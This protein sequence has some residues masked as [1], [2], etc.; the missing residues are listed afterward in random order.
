MIVALG[1]RG[2][3]QP[4]VALG[5]GLARAGH[6]VRVLT[7]SDFQELVES[8]GLEFVNAGGSTEA[9][10]KEMQD[11][12]EQGN[13]LKILKK[14]GEAANELSLEA[15]KRGLAA[16][17]GCELIIAGLGGLSIASSLA[18]KLGVRFIPAYLYPYSPTREFPSVL[19]GIPQ[20]PLTSWLNPLS[21]RLGQQMMWQA[22]RSSTNRARR[23]VFGLQ[24]AAFWG[25]SEGSRQPGDLVLYGYSPHVI[26]VPRD[27][28]DRHV[29]TGYWFLDESD[30]WAPPSE[31][32]DFLNAGPAPVYVGF[33]SMGSKNAESTA[34]LVLEA[35]RRTGQRGVL[36]AGW[37]GL[38]KS[39]VPDGVLMVGSVPHSWLFSRMAAVVHHGGAGT[40][41]AGFRAGVPAI[42]TPVLGDQPFWARRAHAL[43]VAPPPVMRRHLTVE[44]LAE[45]ITQATT[46]AAMRRKA[47]DLGKKIRGDDGVARAI[48]ALFQ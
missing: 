15:A 25:A 46:D 12:L 33:G 21:H 14:M 18:E 35:L 45:A 13:F 24:R 1:S 32:A 34:D 37:G 30:D 41:A 4:H 39:S 23:E 48:E 6:S 36:S 5:V 20:T 47:A 22:T 28:D 11:L 31:L 10:A 16:C 19:V 42:I 26:P 9:V 3:V 44:R 40:T 2:D 7:S 17:E 8:H 27:W 29:V 43:G 38:E